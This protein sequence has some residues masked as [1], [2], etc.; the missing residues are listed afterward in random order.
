MRSQHRVSTGGAADGLPGALDVSLHVGNDVV[1]KRNETSL[2]T[3]TNNSKKTL[4]HGSEHHYNA[5]Y[6]LLQPS[7]ACYSA[8]LRLLLCPMRAPTFMR[9]GCTLLLLY[10]TAY[11]SLGVALQRGDAF[12]LPG[13]LEGRR[14][15]H[16]STQP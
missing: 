6:Q 16:A 4:Q 11:L 13:G 1:H 3:V 2:N 12:Y 15:A 9:P 7:A 10:W 8:V 5:R 14:R